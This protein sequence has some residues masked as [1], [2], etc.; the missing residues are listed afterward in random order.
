VQIT[1]KNPSGDP[2]AGTGIV[3]DQHHILTCAHVVKD[4]DVDKVQI[5]QGFE[6]HIEQCFVHP[7]AD[8]AVVR[9][10]RFLELAVGLS[11]LSPRI[12]QPVFTLGYPK[13]PFVREAALTMQRGEVTN[14]LVTTFDG[15]KVFLYSAIARPGNSGGPIISSEGYVIGISM[16]DLFQQDERNPFSPHYAGIPTHQIAQCLDELDIGVQIPVEDFN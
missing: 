9:V 15:H 8:V 16:Q 12:A 2:C 4:V 5:F 6:H 10:R 1:G 11:F 3:F 7:Q 14:E 13:I